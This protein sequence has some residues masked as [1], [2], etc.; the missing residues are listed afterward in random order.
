MMAMTTPSHRDRLIEAGVATIHRGGFAA[1]GVREVMAAAGVPQGSFTNHFRSKEAFGVAVL[2]RYFERLETMMT[3]TL[4]D[5][6]RPPVDRLQA[7]VDLVAER[8]EAVGWRYGCLVANMGLEA[9]EHSEAMRERLTGILAAQTAAFAEVIGAGQRA[10]AIRR[11]Q[12]ADDLAAVLLAAWQG[13][14]LRAK[15]DRQGQPVERF[16]A[17]LLG[18][19]VADRP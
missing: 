10:G 5:A 1:T 14:L 3:A 9:P 7:Y 8:M 18:L 12:D 15:V 2:D 17:V 16:K 6:T 19:L 11:D 13:T 4:S